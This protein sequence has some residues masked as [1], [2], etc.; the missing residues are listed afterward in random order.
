MLAKNNEHPDSYESNHN[1][2]EIVYILW[3]ECFKEVVVKIG[4]TTN[5]SRRLEILNTAV[6]TPF[7]CVRA[8][9]VED[10]HSVEKELH[11]K[12]ADFRTTPR[13][14]FFKVDPVI[15]KA[16]L[17]KYEIEDVTEMWCVPTVRTK[18][19]LNKLDSVDISDLPTESLTDQN[20]DDDDG[21]ARVGRRS[22]D[23]FNRLSIPLES[24]LTF[25]YD[26]KVTCKVV[27]LDP[28]LVQFNG[29]HLSVSEAAR[30]AQDSRLG[31]KT[32]GVNGLKYW[33]Y[34]GRTLWE[35]DQ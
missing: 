14:E 29:V 31:K 26:K 9:R 6:P 24:N 25:I 28:S 32:G 35:L 21:Q 8:S 15:V 20:P 4:Q 18:G 2:D 17:K 23:V 22:Q 1:P 13:G 5:V 34:L 30:R 16:E 7:T 27:Q 12:F 33:K 19:L 11:K 10:R 3:N